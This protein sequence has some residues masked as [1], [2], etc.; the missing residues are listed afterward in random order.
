MDKN[1]ERRLTESKQRLVDNIKDWVLSQDDIDS[2]Q[3]ISEAIEE[4]KQ[5]LLKDKHEILQELWDI[6]EEIEEHSD[7]LYNDKYIRESGKSS[8]LRLLS[9]R[10]NDVRKQIKEK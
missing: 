3:V 8:G 9:M 1:W 5:T 2:L 10:I 7:V 4:R 6:S